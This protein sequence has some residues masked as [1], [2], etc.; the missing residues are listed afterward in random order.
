[1]TIDLRA[2]PVPLAV[3]ADGV[4]RVAGTRVTLDSLVAAFHE[5]FGADEIAQQYPSLTL[6]DVY[7]VIGYYLRHRSTIDACLGAR[8]ADHERVR[9]ENESRSDSRGLR[10]RLLARRSEERS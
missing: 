3:D 9:A 10:A 6:A 2:E 7:S 8:Q 1:M 5:G 4:V